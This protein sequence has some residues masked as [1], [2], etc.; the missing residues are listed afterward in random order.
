MQFD[1]CILAASG[2]Q[3]APVVKNGAVAR[4]C[5]WKVTLS[6]D[7]RAADGATGGGICKRLK[8][9]LEETGKAADLRFSI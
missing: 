8:L 1:A 6:C 3:Q 2:I 7:H 5:K 4:Q 9:L